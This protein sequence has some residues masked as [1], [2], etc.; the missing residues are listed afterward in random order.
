MAPPKPATAEAMTN[1]A[2]L[3]RLAY[4]PNWAMRSGSSRAMSRK[5]PNTERR[6]FQAARKTSAVAAAMRT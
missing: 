5:V 6:T 1:A 2:I 4:P 3:I